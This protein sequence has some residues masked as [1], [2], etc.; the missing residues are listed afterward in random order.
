MLRSHV[1]T[2][3]VL[4]ALAAASGA[5][6][7]DNHLTVDTTSGHPGDQIVIKAGYYAE[8]TQFTIGGGRLLEDGDIAVYDLTTPLADSD[9][10]NGWYA[11]LDLL[12]TSDF[13]FAS[14]RLNGGL[15]RYELASLVPLSGGPGVAAWGDFDDEGGVEPFN[16]SAFSGAASRLDRSFDVG[17]AEHDELQGMA[18]SAPGL[19]D[20]TFIAWDSNGRY[21]DSAPVTV[22]FNVVPAPA[23]ALPLVGGLMMLRRRAR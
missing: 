18:F 5:A 17:L 3:T 21:T 13:F 23:A 2:L 7:A 22:R 14:G 4:G 19:Y 12:I 20:L 1:R 16:P 10:Y 8:E 9:P 6:L 11:G 15:F